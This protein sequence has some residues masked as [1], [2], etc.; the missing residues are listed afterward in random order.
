MSRQKSYDR[1]Y[2]E[3]WYRSPRYRVRTSAELQRQV[4]FVLR[5]TEF[6]IGRPVRTVLDVGCGEGQWRPVLRKFRPRVEYTGVDPS[7]YVVERFG[8]QRN[9]VAGAADSLSE[10]N[11]KGPFDLVACSG[12]L[13]Y[14]TREE[15]ARGLREIAS[16][17]GGVA[18]LELFSSEDSCEGDTDW[19]KPASTKWY[20]QLMQRSGL[21]PIG[22]QCY[23]LSKDRGRMSA[24]E[25]M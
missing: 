24:L 21:V 22:M 17:M 23:V 16:Q 14:L 20:R 1:A 7:S 6:V 5:T 13:N 12:V 19:P 18:Y 4:Q 15:L 9:I 10:L 2:F 3:K 11:L 8:R 25:I